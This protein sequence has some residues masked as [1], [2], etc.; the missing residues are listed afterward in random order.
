MDFQVNFWAIV[1]CAILS[2]VTG[3]VWYG[4]LFS[5]AW[6]SEMG[7]DPANSTHLVQMQKQAKPAYLQQFTGAVIM[8]FIFAVILK[9]LHSMGLGQPLLA[10]VIIWLGFIAP[11][12]YGDTLWGKSTL[13]LFLI[14]SLYYL[15]NLLVFAVVLA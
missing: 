5:N 15:V 14:D 4:P 10:A 2:M 8:A 7:W 11:L 12:K 13:K 3:F 1:I 9:N 6:M